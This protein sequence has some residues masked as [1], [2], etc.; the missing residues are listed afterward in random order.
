MR[1]DHGAGVGVEA[2]EGI[3][4]ADGGNDAAH[5]A[6]EVDV[7]LGGDFAGDDHEAGCSQRFA[8]TRL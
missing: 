6:L 7:G 8:A 4:V 1:R 3:V 5:Q 2:V